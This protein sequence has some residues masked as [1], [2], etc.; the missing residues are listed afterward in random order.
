[1]VLMGGN[2]ALDEFDHL[3]EKDADIYARFLGFWGGVNDTEANHND[4]TAVSG[5]PVPMSWRSR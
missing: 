5:Q 1:M 3:G 4:K 2:A